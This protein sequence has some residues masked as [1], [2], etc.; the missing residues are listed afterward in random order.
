M[1]QIARAGDDQHSVSLLRRQTPKLSPQLARRP[2]LRRTAILVQPI[3][4]D[5]PEDIHCWK[6]Y[7][8]R[9]LYEYPVFKIYESD[10][11]ELRKSDNPFDLAHYAGIQAWMQRGSDT[12]KLDY[13]KLLLA[14]W[15]GADRTTSKKWRFFGS[16]KA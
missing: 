2:H 7:E 11:D 6:G 15:T 5:Q 16:S 3:L 9:I 12:R 1:Q 8:A 14:E 4:V 13:M 10:E